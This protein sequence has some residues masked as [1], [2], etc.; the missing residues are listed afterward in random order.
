MRMV[1]GAL[2]LPVTVATEGAAVVA[3]GTYAAVV[4]VEAMTVVDWTDWTDCREESDETT[5]DETDSAIAEETEAGSATVVDNGEEE[6]ETAAATVWLEVA[7][8]ALA[9][10]GVKDNTPEEVGTTASEDML[11]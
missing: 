7:V 11:D 2:V 1:D 4:G 3:G 5:A 10:L 6:D 8:M 9:L